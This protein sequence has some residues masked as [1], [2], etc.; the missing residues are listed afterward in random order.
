MIAV[1]DGLF[2]RRTRF[3]PTLRT[4]DSL[5]KSFVIGVEVKKVILGIDAI[6]RFVGSQDCFKEPGSVADVPTRRTHEVSRLD[7][8]VL[9]F[10]RR[11]DLH[12]ARAYLNVEIGDGNSLP[13]G[14]V[15]YC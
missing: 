1:G 14:K 10:E 4:L 5:A 11:D 9:D 3:R 13:P 15:A 7:D 2:D 12:R 8:V 6:A